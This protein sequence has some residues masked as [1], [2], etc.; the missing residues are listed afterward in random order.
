VLRLRGQGEQS[1]GEDRKR[2]T[3]VI[4]MNTPVFPLISQHLL[5]VI[6]IQPEMLANYSRRRI[7]KIRR[8]KPGGKHDP[9]DCPSNH[10]RGRL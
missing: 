6:A 1:N 9:E 8:V 5:P 7:R 4:V 2:E 3:T 10:H